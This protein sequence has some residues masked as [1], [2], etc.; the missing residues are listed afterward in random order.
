MK[1][2]KD[3]N[4]HHEIITGGFLL[5]STIVY[6]ANHFDII[7]LADETIYDLGFEFR[8]GRIKISKT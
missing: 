7:D 1:L 8:S 6:D 3:P 2:I 4:K 5:Y